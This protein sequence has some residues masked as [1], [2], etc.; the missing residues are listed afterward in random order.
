MFDSF[1]PS[2]DGAV[3]YRELNK[4]LRRG[5]EVQLSAEMQLL[6]EPSAGPEAKDAEAWARAEAKNQ[7]REVAM[8]ARL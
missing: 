1:D 8:A 7:A 4:F 2:G 6:Q 5:N 3:D